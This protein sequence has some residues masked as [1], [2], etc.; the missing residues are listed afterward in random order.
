MKPRFS[1]VIPVHNRSDYLAQALASCIGQTIGDF[2]VV[3]SDDCSSENL[4]A[5]VESCA[6]SRVRYSRSEERLGAVKN[7]QRAVSLA[8]GEHVLILHSDDFLLPQC[9]EAAGE[10]LDANPAAAAV[11]YSMTYLVGSRIE[12]FNTMPRIRF[13]DK[14]TLLKN[15]WL[16]KFNATAPTCCVF[17]RE[18]F[19]A[20]GGYRTSLR[21]IYDYDLYMR[22]LT[23]GGGVVFLPQILCVYRKHDEQMTWTSN[24][25]GLCDVLDLWCWKEY[26]HWP[27]SQVAEIVLT[28]LGRLARAKL[29]FGPVLQHVQQRG[30]TWRLLRGMPKA[31]WIKLRQRVFPARK[32]QHANYQSP[33]DP[34]QALRT[35]RIVLGKL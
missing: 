9:L 1:V 32:N 17:R 18:A 7:H 12:G 11:Y 30:L 35:A 23:T 13:A 29:S 2:E 25:D 31:L 8:Q 20:F 10:A 26:S 24:L 4:A 28:Q 27:P 16:E 5:V 15:E 21:F 6:D 19:N 3:V 33:V 14:D 22:F 34:E